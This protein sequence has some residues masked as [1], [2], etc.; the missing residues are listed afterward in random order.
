MPKPPR[1]DQLDFGDQAKPARGKN[2]LFTFAKMLSRPAFFPNKMAPGVFVAGFGSVGSKVPHRL[3]TSL[4]P[5]CPSHRSPT[6]S[7]KFGLTLISS[8]KK[9]DG[10]LLRMPASP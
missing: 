9:N 2:T 8:W 7:V 10:F 6:F 3:C 4:K 1:T 5:P